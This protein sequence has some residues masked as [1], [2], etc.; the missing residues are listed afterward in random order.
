MVSPDAIRTIRDLESNIS[1]GRLYDHSSG[2]TLIAGTPNLGIAEVC[3][4]PSPPVK[5]M[6]SSTE[7]AST[8]SSRLAF[9]NVEALGGMGR[10]MTEGKGVLAW[11]FKYAT[12]IVRGFSGWQT[13]V[14]VGKNV[15]SSG[16][17]SRDRNQ[18]L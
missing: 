10:C 11:G 6:A 13:S 14:R 15:K 4:K 12:V 9:A 8:I 5:A 18:N 17:V 1:L 16:S 7:R 2:Y 3:Q